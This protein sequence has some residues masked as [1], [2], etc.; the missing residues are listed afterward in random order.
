MAGW[1]SKT[2]LPQG[3]DPSDVAFEKWEGLGND[4]VVLVDPI[5]VPTPLQVSA[6]CDRRFGLGADGVLVV[7][8]TPPSMVVFNADGSRP[9]MCG[10]GLRC[11]VA[12][13]AEQLRV[14]EGELW[15]ETDAGP[16]SARYRRTDGRSFEVE[17]NMGAPSFDP[18]LAFATPRDGTRVVGRPDVWELA[19][20]GVG[21][22]AIVSIGNP[23]WIFV[24]PDPDASLATWG[25]R[26]EHDERFAKATN[27]EWVEV[28]G[29]GRSRVDVWERGCGLT[30]ACGS[31]AVATAAL[32]VRL[33][34]A[35]IDQPQEI[36]LPGGVLVCTVLQTGAV[37]MRG[38]ARRVAQGWLRVRD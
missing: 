22:G 17:I 4:F 38:P 8:T 29:A 26:L 6:W 18:A 3:V 14:D 35:T 9:E 13:V 2:T 19:V 15:V 24:A 10:N 30:L 34:H 11:V 37:V 5:E 36:V 1:L 31:G 27:V 32:L 21:R 23:H 33:G 28:L 16:R 7:G 12:A 25:P 20:E